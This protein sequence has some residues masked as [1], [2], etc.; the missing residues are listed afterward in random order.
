M[1]LEVRLSFLQLFC[2]SFETIS[3]QTYCC[4]PQFSTIIKLVKMCVTLQ[5]RFYISYLRVDSLPLSWVD[6]SIH[7][8]L[9]LVRQS[10]TLE[11]NNHIKKKHIERYGNNLSNRKIMFYKYRIQDSSC[12]GIWCPKFG[13]EHRHGVLGYNSLCLEI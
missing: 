5:L 7:M 8:R 6:S 12:I 1:T 10:Q 11:S 4:L 2:I 9:G 3:L 13:Y